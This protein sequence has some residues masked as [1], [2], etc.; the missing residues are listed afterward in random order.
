MSQIHITEKDREWVSG[1]YPDLVI[2]EGIP[3]RLTGLLK[4]KALRGNDLPEIRDEYQI[5]IELSDSETSSLPQVEETGGRLKRVAEEK[6][7]TELADL[8]SGPQSGTLCL[9]SPLEEDELFSN[10]FSLDEFFSGT[11]IPFFYAQSYFEKNDEW[12]WEH[13]GHGYHGLLESYGAIE[14]TDCVLAEKCLRLLKQEQKIWDVCKLHLTR[15]G[16]VKG[17]WQCICGSTQILR[18]CHHGVL[19]GLRKLKQDVSDCSI[20]I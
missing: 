17:H 4:F 16:Y 19:D 8:H 12:P 20:D 6:G 7:I 3:I 9:C 14:E 11:L 1:N 2:H 13:Y 10:G 18:K 5:E 15:K